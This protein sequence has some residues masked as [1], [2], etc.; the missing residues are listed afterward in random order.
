MKFFKMLM[1]ESAINIEL[2]V[3]ILMLW[4]FYR[5]VQIVEN[6]QDVDFV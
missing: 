1:E 4:K 5:D 2:V 3:N 6:L